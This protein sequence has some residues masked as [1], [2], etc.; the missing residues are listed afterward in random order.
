M[1]YTIVM[2]YGLGNQLG[3]LFNGVRYALQNNLVFD[4]FFE[5]EQIA[6]L[7]DPREPY[8]DK[9]YSCK[10]RFDRGNSTFNINNLY[11]DWRDFTDTKHKIMDIL[12][13]GEKR[14]RVLLKYKHYTDNNDI[15]LHFRLGDFVKRGWALDLNHYIRSLNY[16]RDFVSARRI[17]VFFEEQSRKEVNRRISILS[18]MYPEFRF[19]LID[20]SIP[21]YEQLFLMS[22]FNVYVIGNGSFSGWG[23]YLNDNPDKIVLGSSEYS[24]RHEILENFIEIK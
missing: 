13:I 3:F 14:E 6:H 4:V 15:C 2:C 5:K 23:V 12:K 10:R 1:V 21:D 22:G 18:N 16:L 20:T 9:V 11:M 19:N 17:L 24:Q 8:F 7:Y